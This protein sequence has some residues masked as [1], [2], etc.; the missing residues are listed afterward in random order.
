MS[1]STFHTRHL[2]VIGLVLTFLVG[3]KGAKDWPPPSS[4]K[5]PT[6]FRTSTDRATPA[7]PSHVIHDLK[8]ATPDIHLKVNESYG[9]LPLSFE[10]NQG[11]VDSEV[12]FLSRGR[13][14][15]LYLT[16]T[17]AVLQLP[18][19]ELQIS[20]NERRITKGELQIPNFG[21]QIK[22]REPMLPNRHLAIGNRNLQ[23]G[24]QK[25][26]YLRMQLVGANPQAQVEGLEPLP[27]KSNYFLG[28]DPQKWRAN[29]STYSKVKYR[30]VYPGID[31]VYYGNQQQLEYD[32]IVAPGADPKKIR[33]AFQGA[34]KIRLDQSG[35][36][37]LETAGG[38]IRQHRPNVYQESNG[39]R[40]ELEGGY[41]LGK[42]NQVQF[43]VARYDVTKPL[44]IDPVLVYSTFLGGAANDTGCAIA[45]DALGNVYIA[46]ST[47][48]V[49]FPTLGP[50][51]RANRGN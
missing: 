33:L 13:G 8:P 7:F 15:N 14:Y 25:S 11:Q 29:I 38:E 50:A 40:T 23:I 5:N 4:A 3:W 1:T 9:R 31:L 22:N 2:V 20:N 51:Q 6:K 17:E 18:I 45:V 24:N 39:S 49:D 12:R 30:E 28:N 43:E 41:V 32:W 36:L 16:S 48:S 19:D 26:A 37:R 10:V 46:G 21:F 42:D 47:E 35:N 34:K 27:G 44:I